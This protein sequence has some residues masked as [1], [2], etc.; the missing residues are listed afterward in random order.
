VIINIVKLNLYFIILFFMILHLFFLH[1]I[2]NPLGLNS[3]FYKIPFNIYF[4]Y[5]DLYGFILFFI[6]LMF[7]NLHPFLFNE[8]YFQISELSLILK[9]DRE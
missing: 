2:K 4:T 1:W 9:F 8:N 6:I 3:D 5:K 7:I